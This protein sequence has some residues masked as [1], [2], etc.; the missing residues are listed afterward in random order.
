MTVVS[1]H[2]PSYSV[3]CGDYVT[4]TIRVQVPLAL[5]S[6]ALG[7]PHV[8]LRSVGVAATYPGLHAI[9]HESPLSRLLLTLQPPMFWLLPSTMV[10]GRAASTQPTYISHNTL[11]KRTAYRVSADVKRDARACTYGRRCPGQ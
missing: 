8:V 10:H 5:I 6:V 3:C 2:R 4:E 7:V 9:V 1:I 11:F